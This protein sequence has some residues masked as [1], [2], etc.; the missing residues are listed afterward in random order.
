[1]SLRPWKLLLLSSCLLL[2]HATTAVFVSRR[3]ASRLLRVRR[4]NDHGLEE[5]LP[6]SLERECMEERCSLEE[7]M[8]IFP[9]KEA[10]KSFWYKYADG[11]QCASSP[12]H[13]GTC[14]DALNSYSCVCPDGY[15]GVNCEI[16]T[17]T[18][19]Y[20]NGGCE[21]FCSE[22]GNNASV[23]CGCA[24]GYALMDNGTCS[25]QV[26]FPCGRRQRQK[27][28][29]HRGGDDLRIV[30]GWR[31]EPGEC[32]WQVLL[33]SYETGK[34]L[35][36][37][38]LLNDE[39][40]ITAAHCI[41]GAKTQGG[42]ANYVIIGEYDVD[43]LDGSEQ[44]LPVRRVVLHKRHVAPSSSSSSSSSSPLPPLPGPRRRDYDVALLQLATR[45][46]LG[47]SA[48]PLC[49][50]STSLS[51]QQ[52]L[53]PGIHG[54][55]S[56]WGRLG[57]G[58]ARASVLQAVSVP[59]VPHAECVRALGSAVTRNMFCAGRS[60]DD[61]GAG[62]GGRLGDA[63]G[64]DSGGPHATLYGDTFFLTGIVSWGDGCARSGKYGVYT[65]VSRF[66]PWIREVM[67]RPEVKA[68]LPSPPGA[69]SR[70]RSSSQAPAAAGGATQEG[71]S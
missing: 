31:C 11:D 67:G 14:K 26:E 34:G 43:V 60:A 42:L 63:C 59:F 15:Q 54:L 46:R 6:G 13:A 32:P 21:H 55:V 8:E 28:A 33:V 37:G 10:A 24:E 27:E 71:T 39:W 51:E 12:C 36:G 68:A 35:C 48:V 18:C 45:A 7:A 3:E 64:G 29:K 49:L 9:D 53:M 1:M 47:P 41:V 20:R 44:Y 2:L 66:V 5:F 65:K 61:D 57:E 56:G 52:L 22:R 19:G 30:N 17:R 69:D 58:A 62:G 70:E 23:R 50:P 25:P 40:V 4:V 38:A 16:N